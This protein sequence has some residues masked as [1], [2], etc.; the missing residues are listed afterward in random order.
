MSFFIKIVCSPRRGATLM[1]LDGFE[2][3]NRGEKRVM[4]DSG[5]TRIET[6]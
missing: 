6:S 5:G 1:I 4:G 2:K 3:I